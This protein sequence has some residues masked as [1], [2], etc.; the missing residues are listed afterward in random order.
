MKARW[1][2]LKL[3]TLSDLLREASSKFN[4][5]TEFLESILRLERV[6]L[7]LEASRNS[8]RTRLREMIQEESRLATKKD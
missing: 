2:L 8:V 7:H 1:W 5:R 6:S 3:A 4:I